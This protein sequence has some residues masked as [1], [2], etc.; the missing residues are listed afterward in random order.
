M[1]HPRPDECFGAFR[2]VVPPRAEEVPP[3]PKP[4]RSK[5][6]ARVFRKEHSVFKDWKEDT[7]ETLD[8][9]FKYDQAHWK[10]PRFI[11]DEKDLANVEKTIKRHY[12]KLKR[13]FIG[14]ASHSG[15]PNIKAL[16]YSDFASHCKLLDQNLNLAGIDR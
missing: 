5:Q 16:A 12:K 15:F 4:L 3:Y 11:K 8:K 13:I 6:V 14:E 10:L 2:C 1:L 7:Q 9:C